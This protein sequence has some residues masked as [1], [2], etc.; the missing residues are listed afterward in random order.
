VY[1]NQFSVQIINAKETADGYIEIAHNTQYAIKLQNDRS[2]NC[3]A[4]VTID[5]QHVGTWIVPCHR[6]IT[7]ER[8]VQTPKLFTFYQ[9]GSAEAAQAQLQ[10]N[11]DLGLI[12]VLF[13]PAKQQPLAPIMSVAAS[14]QS[15]SGGTGLSGTSNQ[16]FIPARD[17][18]YDLENTCMIHLRLIAPTLSDIQPLTPTSTPIPPRL[19]N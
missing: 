9:L 13:K 1:L 17:L 4:V 18:D 5:G 2:V 19:P 15:R 11:P 3:A 16:Q 12:S 8:P 7:V 14:S 6:N 10:D